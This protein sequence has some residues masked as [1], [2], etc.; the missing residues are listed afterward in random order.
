MKLSFKVIG[1]TLTLII[2]AGVLVGCGDNNPGIPDQALED[3]TAEI[4]RY[5]IV[6]DTLIEIDEDGST[7]IVLTILVDYGTTEEKAKELGDSFVRLLASFSA[8]YNSESESPTRDSIGSLYDDYSVS[9][10]VS[11]D[12]DNA[13]AGSNVGS[14]YIRW[15]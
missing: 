15:H 14:R 1:L 10:I 9:V 11:P 6:R 2:F 3:A 7:D 5:D 4:E 12:A 8:V 13:I